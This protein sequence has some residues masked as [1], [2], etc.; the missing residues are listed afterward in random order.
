MSFTMAKGVDA[1]AADH[2]QDTDSVP[3]TA[4]DGGAEMNT[5]T[6]T[7]NADLVAAS[8]KGAIG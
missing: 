4:A 2:E 1:V 5:R 7:L 8:D 3:D 6:E